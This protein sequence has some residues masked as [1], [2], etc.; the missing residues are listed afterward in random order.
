ML[1]DSNPIYVI[2][3][4]LLESTVESIL[5]SSILWFRLFGMSCALSYFRTKKWYYPNTMA[6][7]IQIIK[8][9]KGVAS[10]LS[11]DL[12]SIFNHTIVERPISNVRLKGIQGEIYI[13]P[14]RSCIREFPCLRIRESYERPDL[15]YLEPVIPLTSW[16]NNKPN[17]S[18]K[19]ELTPYSP[20]PPMNY[21][22]W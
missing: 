10:I 2:R 14:T 11:L 12:R 22:Y 4:S 3:L 8:S 6:S 16:T 9:R 15:P 13:Q 20:G 5:L 1:W 17:T 7:H 19:L 21:S 18:N